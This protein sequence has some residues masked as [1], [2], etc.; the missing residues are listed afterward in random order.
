MFAEECFRK[1]DIR[2]ALEDLKKQ[3]RSH[4]ENSRYRIFF[5]Q[6]LVVT[7]DWERAL[8][9]LDV[10]ADLDDGTLPMVHLYRTAIACEILR[11]K[12]FAGNLQP[13]IFGE[14]PEWMA[15]QLE[16]LRM[17][18]DKRF[19]QAISLRDQAFEQAKASS[20]TIDGDAF[21]WIADAD[22]RLGPVLEIIVNGQYYWVPY[23]RV[24]TVTIEAP[25]DL[26]DFVWLPA[27]FKWENGGEI[28]GLIPSRYPGSEHSADSS[29]QLARKTEWKEVAKGVH[30][31]MGQRLLATDQ[32]DYPLLDIRQIGITSGKQ[33]GFESNQGF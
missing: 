8:N 12:I 31:G 9:Q 15:L 11:T 26:R 16:A 21:E 4:P 10:V 22:S 18:A 32:S 28:Y 30:H 14:P 24:L 19:D 29:I 20:G 13:T 25:E 27:L 17:T 1:G 7:G 5:F 23:E 2:A 3:I 33:S 6:L